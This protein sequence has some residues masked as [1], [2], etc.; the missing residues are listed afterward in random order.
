VLKVELF[1]DTAITIAP[2]ILSAT[3][4]FKHIKVN[5]L[6][7]LLHKHCA[8]RASLVYVVELKLQVD[9]HRGV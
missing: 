2:V 7:M 4:K 6:L 1:A 8:H 5:K 3:S 9:I